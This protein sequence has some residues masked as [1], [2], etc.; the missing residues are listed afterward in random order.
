MLGCL[1][2]PGL[3]PREG[4]AR[5]GCLCASRLSLAPSPSSVSWCAADTTV[6]HPC[7]GHYLGALCHRW[8]AGTWCQ[9]QHG[10]SKHWMLSVLSRLGPLPGTA[11]PSR[12][13]LRKCIQV[14]TSWTG[15]AAAPLPTRGTDQSPGR[16]CL[17]IVSDGHS[18]RGEA[19][20]CGI[21][22]N[23]DSSALVLSPREGSSGLRVG[24]VYFWQCLGQGSL[25]PFKGS[26][27][28]IFFLKERR[29]CTCSMGQEVLSSS[30]EV[31]PCLK[32]PGALSPL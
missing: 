5:E 30:Y 14:Y 31:G 21:P 16:M 19:E 13:V 29:E 28:V 23:R 22:G 20:P 15:P 32:F 25:C 11:G 2:F 7:G 10:H 4:A 24:S 9:D 1:D 26:F 27:A 6:Y 12:T 3:V 18:S 17:R 8:I